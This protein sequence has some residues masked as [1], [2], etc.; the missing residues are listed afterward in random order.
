M[1]LPD[2]LKIVIFEDILKIAKKGPP[3]DPWGNAYVLN[4]KENRHG[5]MYL[6]ITYRQIT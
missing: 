1:D 5:H 2:I 4:T 3:T 6:T